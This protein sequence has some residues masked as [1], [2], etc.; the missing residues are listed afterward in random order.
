MNVPYFV[1]PLLHSD[2]GEGRGEEVFHGYPSLPTRSSQGRNDA[3]GW[4]A[5]APSR[6]LVDALVHQAGRR[7]MRN[8]LVGLS[9]SGWF[10]ARRVERHARAR[11]LPN[12]TASF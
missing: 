11:A 6:V 12:P 2:G 10:D 7:K 9:A 4:G 5:Y 3:V 8:C 1:L